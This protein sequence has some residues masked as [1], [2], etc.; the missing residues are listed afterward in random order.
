MRTAEYLSDCPSHIGLR[1]T[2]DL[3]TRDYYDA[4]PKSAVHSV[5][6]E[7]QS[8]GGSKQFPSDGAFSLGAIGRNLKQK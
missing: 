4:S 2:T 8:L 6:H 5:R 7:Y 3:I 1:N